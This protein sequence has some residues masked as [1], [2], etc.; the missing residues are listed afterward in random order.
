VGT[1]TPLVSQVGGHAGVS[2]SEDG[3]L[4]FKPALAR[5]VSFYQHLNSDPVSAP[6][7]PYI[8]KFYGTLRFEGKVEDVNLETIRE[9]PKEG[10]DKCLSTWES[11]SGDRPCIYDNDT[12]D[13]IGESYQ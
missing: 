1:K 7:R 4:L 13:S 10:K 5:E 8:P 6:L 2:T 12:F 3:S 11:P 9:A